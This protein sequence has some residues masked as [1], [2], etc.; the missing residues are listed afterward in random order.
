MDLVKKIVNLDFFQGR[1]TYI[2]GGAM[3][4][5]AGSQIVIDL[6]AGKTPDQMILLEFFNGLGFIGL[7]KAM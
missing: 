1:K 6:F 3:M 7:R 2:V 4:L 5:H